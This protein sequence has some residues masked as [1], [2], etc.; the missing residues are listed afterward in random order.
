MQRCRSTQVHTYFD[1]YSGAY[2]YIMLGT[3]MRDFHATGS[4]DFDRRPQSS[5]REHLTLAAS[6]A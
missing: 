4:R 3:D 5:I 1:V 2:T 6:D